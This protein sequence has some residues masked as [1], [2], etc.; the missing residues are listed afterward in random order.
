MEN[1]LIVENIEKYYGKFKAVDKISFNVKKGDI[2]GF[3]G[4]N[5]SG[6]TTTIKILAGLLPN[7]KGNIYYK[8]SKVNNIAFFPET[9]FIFDNQNFYDNLTAF[10]NIEIISR[11][12]KNYNKKKI[13]EALDIVGLKKWINFPV[14]KF[15][16]GMRQRLAIAIAE[17][18]MPEFLI[19]DEPTNGLDIEGIRDLEK[20]F[21]NLNKNLGTTILLSSHY[22]EQIERLSDHIIIINKGKKIFDSRIE[23]FKRN[24]RIGIKYVLKKAIENNYIEYIKNKIKDFINK[25][26]SFESIREFDFSLEINENE[27]YLNIKNNFNIFEKDF[28]NIFNKYI[29]DFFENSL[30]Y[31]EPINK[32]LECFFI[33]EVEDFDKLNCL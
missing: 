10:E 9:K 32:N 13:L 28:L 3:L 14:K 1:I 5:G 21:L 17:I 4:P 2:L 22:L 33:D 29:I 11:Y 30:L 19:L 6:K 26:I 12:N 18:S 24:S 25:N 7:Y 15:S 20:Y 27:L 16:R 8:N 23:D 31:I